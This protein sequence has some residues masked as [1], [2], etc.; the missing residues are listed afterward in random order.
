[1]FLG[2][3]KSLP[4]SVAN[5]RWT[6]SRLTHKYL[7]RLERLARKNTLAYYEHS[8]ITAV[9]SLTTLGPEHQSH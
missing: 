1:M 2:K 5:E 3:A 6:G 9:K 7:T 4:K 8:S